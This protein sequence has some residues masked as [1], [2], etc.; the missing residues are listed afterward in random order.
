MGSGG[1]AQD[2]AHA[3]KDNVPDAILQAVGARELSSAEKV[4][5]SF[6][7]VSAYGSFAEV[8]ADPLVDICYVASVH[9]FHAPHA[10]LAISHGKHVLVEKA[11]TQNAKQAAEVLEAA[12]KKGVFVMEAYWTRFMPW[13]RKMREVLPLLGEVRHVTCD[14]SI[15]FSRDA[16]RI[17]DPNLCGGAL[18]DVGIYP[19]SVSSLIFGS[20]APQKIVACG[21][22]LDTGVDGHLA[23][24]LVY[25]PFRTAQLF[26]GA[27]VDG[28]STLQVFGTKGR[29]RVHDDATGYWHCATGLTLSLRQT[30][31]SYTDQV[32]DFPKPNATGS[33]NY[34]NSEMLCYEAQEVQ[35]CVAEGK[36]ESASM[37]QAETL[38]IMHTLDE[39]R[40]QVGAVY[41]DEK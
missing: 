40:K 36:T 29:I 39:I 32:F 16:K 33:Y 23:I 24:T 10:L 5:N 17:F 7:F 37:S 13:A 35:R 38:T 25:G 2:F 14:F 31:G 21:D 9:N 41:P 20:G 22:L 4:K 6:G 1:I 11:F 8:A 12:K 26:C 18:L 3:L 34:K 30:D 15:Q 19:I 28:S 27:L